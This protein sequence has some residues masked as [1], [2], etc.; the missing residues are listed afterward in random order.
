[1]STGVFGFDIKVT[2]LLVGGD[3]THGGEKGDGFGRLLADK[4]PDR[5]PRDL[6]SRDEA[7]GGDGFVGRSTEP[8]AS[9]GPVIK[10]KGALAEKHAL[11][12]LAHDMGHDRRFF[13]LP[14]H[15][16]PVEPA[17]GKHAKRPDE[18]VLS[19]ADV[20]RDEVLVA[21]EDTPETTDVVDGRKDEPLPGDEL[22]RP[23]TARKDDDKRLAVI[24]TADLVAEDAPVPPV[25][26]FPPPAERNSIVNGAA[27]DAGM[28]AGEPAETG[29]VPETRARP[30]LKHIATA[31]SERPDE[32][33][34]ADKRL[35]AMKAPD[36]PERT[37][38]LPAKGRDDGEGSAAIRV[39]NDRRGAETGNAVTHREMSPPAMAADT[40]RETVADMSAT[41][42]L[43]VEARAASVPLRVLDTNRSAGEASRL[44]MAAANTGAAAGEAAALTGLTGNA[45]HALAADDTSRPAVEPKAIAA[46]RPVAA[47]AV[48]GAAELGQTAPIAAGTA[49]QVGATASL[50]QAIGENSDWARQFTGPAGLR[51][52]H[53]SRLERSGETS[54]SLR[55]QLRPVELGAVTATMRLV[56][57][58]LS[59]SLKVEKET[60][61][62]ALQRDQQAVHNALRSLGFQVDDLSI[63]GTQVDRGGSELAGQR[64]HADGGTQSGERR[65]APFEQRSGNARQADAEIMRDNADAATSGIYI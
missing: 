35:E 38:P 32:D 44:A 29:R 57:D 14:T 9:P 3:R 50:L 43:A 20:E 1:M 58:R 64:G 52:D 18:P 27:P 37:Q 49:G 39:G 24:A 36:L 22:K 15:P 13:G 59:V 47:E 41:P 65:Q 48:R 12:E 2:R 46:T 16:R 30:P 28:D 26:D 31:E 6:R 51:A 25:R 11:P 45:G 7:E 19:P 61:L 42:K 23:D 60:T 63:N 33:V 4:A 34:P 53:A 55:I 5:L 10:L 8:P 21:D 40:R 62:G 17:A 54:H 56:G